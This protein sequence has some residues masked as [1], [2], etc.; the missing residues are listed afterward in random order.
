MVAP[1]RDTASATHVAHDISIDITNDAEAIRTLGAIIR[2]G[3]LPN[4]Y[5]RAGRAV[6]LDGHPLQ[7]VPLDPSNMRRLIAHHTYCYRLKKASRKVDAILIEAEGVPGI[8]IC[9]TVLSESEWR[10][11]AE[12][13]GII[14]TPVLAPDGA[15]IQEQGYHRPTQLHY[16]PRLPVP[17]IPDR[18]TAQA[19]AQAR[20]LIFDEVLGDFPWVSEIDKANY[21]ALLIT[22]L[23]R[24]A[25]GSLSPLGAITAAGAG[26]GK[27]LLGVDIPQ[28][29]Y[30]AASRPWVGKEDEIRKAVTGMLATATDPVILLDNVPE[31][32][33]VK[34][35]TLS[36]LLTSRNWTDRPLGE[37]TSGTW[38]N[39]RLWL[40]T[41]NSMTFGGDIPSRTVLVR[42]D[43]RRADPS[44]RTDFVL[45]DLNAW[46]ADDTNATHL[47][48]ALLTLVADWAASGA[49]TAPQA[50][51][52]FT[53]WAKACA[54]FLAH[55][56]LVG[57]LLNKAELETRDDEA[58]MWYGFADEWYKHFGPDW[59]TATEVADSAKQDGMSDYDTW[60][61]RYLLDGTGHRASK[62]SL[63]KQLSAKM[64]AFLGGVDGYRLE[65]TYDTHAKVNRFRIL[66]AAEVAPQAP[67]EPEQAAAAQLD[68]FN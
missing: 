52:Q 14:T 26:T 3:H 21:V 37:S 50:M 60:N 65:A 7:I 20:R 39:D 25:V 24:H 66:P 49:Q 27:T 22:P 1:Q 17:R 58:A 11:G 57:F 16:A 19:V 18:P 48:H 33:S 51:R 53:P 9:N 46:L 30:G 40:L 59:K 12:L 8:D 36:A 13:A 68:M 54:G 62:M 67:A 45:G 55:H 38:P 31:W 29:I 28:A 42:L 61:G 64:G 63:G 5:T 44:A 32:E 56:G 47:L 15:L 10:G 35:P 6:I 34:S 2:R 41:G 43:A 4:V 23:I